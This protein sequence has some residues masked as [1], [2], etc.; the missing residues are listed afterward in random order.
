MTRLALRWA[1]LATALP[2]A[3]CGWLPDAYSGCDEARPYQAAKQAEPLK[4]PAGADLP[5]TRNA[6]KIPEL[7]RP[8]LPRDAGSCLE[9]PPPYGDERPKAGPESPQPSP[10]ASPST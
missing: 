5:D 6:L 3:G 1:A 7:A 8:E 2:L 4:V 10:S 9:H